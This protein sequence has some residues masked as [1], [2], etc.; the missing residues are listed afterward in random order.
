EDRGPR[1]RARRGEGGARVVVRRLQDDVGDLVRVRLQNGVRGV[2]LHR[3][4]TGPFG[5]EAQVVGADRAVVGGDEVPG[6][7]V[8]P[9]GG[10][11]RFVP[12]GGGRGP[13]RGGQYPRAARLEAVAEEDVAELVRL[14]VQIDV[15]GAAAERN[16]VEGG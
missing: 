15:R 12:G 5:H 1:G 16:G 11:A 9:R 13:L 4:R 14:E 3:G 10:G 7:D 8:P 2:D 6:R